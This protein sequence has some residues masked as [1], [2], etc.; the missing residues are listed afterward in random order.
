MIDPSLIARARLKEKHVRM[1]SL[2]FLFVSP[3]PVRESLR[4]L[5][6]RLG[7]G[8]YEF[9]NRIGALPRPHYAHIIYE[10][11]RLASRLGVPRISAIEFGVAGGN[12]LL[13]LEH[14]ADEVE[15][16]FPVTIDIYGFD[17]GGGLPTPKDYRDLP[18]HWESGFFE[19]DTA[20]LDAKLNR[21]KV[22]LGN[23]AE[24]WHQFLEEHD[25]APIGAVSHDFDFYSS[26]M[27]GLMLFDA[28]PKYLMP[29][30]FCYFDD[31]IGGEVELFSDFTG[32]RLAIGDF[33][34][35]HEMRKIGVPYY[36]RVRQALGVWVNQLWV[37][38][39]FDHPRY[40][41]FVSTKNQQLPLKSDG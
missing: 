20:A 1:K 12:G 35:A 31:T 17:T 9:R 18:Y 5:L 28:D 38:H 39:V 30:I 32:E 36:M 21:S 15:K 4:R 2:E 24:T 41:D 13:A 33:N 37:C 11:A 7:L 25:P 29:R 40:N 14:H 16:L 34:K 26:T 8:G 22:I 19:M 10:S 3:A 23:V 27:D 6:A